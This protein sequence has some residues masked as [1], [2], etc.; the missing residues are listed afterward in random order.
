[1]K[2]F[3]QIKHWNLVGTSVMQANQLTFELWRFLRS[4]KHGRVT[5]IRVMNPI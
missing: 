5:D 4:A 1:M 2:I 3:R